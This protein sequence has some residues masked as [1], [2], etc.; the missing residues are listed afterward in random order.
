MDRWILSLFVYFIIVFILLL[1]KPSLM[2]D[3]NG[4]M[5]P[6]GVGFEDGKSVFSPI[7]V[8][9]LLAFLSYFIVSLIYFIKLYWVYN[10][11]YRV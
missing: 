10:I 8:F 3:S 11:D 7:F 2:F 5:K 6:F 4:Q 9:P 1:I